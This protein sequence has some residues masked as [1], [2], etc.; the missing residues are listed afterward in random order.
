MAKLIKNGGTHISADF[1]KRTK[2]A[3]QHTQCE[4]DRIYTPQ[5]PTP[6]GIHN[7]MC[8]ASSLVPQQYIMACCTLPNHPPL[9][10]ERRCT[11]DV[12][13]L[14]KLGAH[15]D[16]RVPDQAGIQGHGLAQRV[17]GARARIEAHDE[18]VSVVVCRLQLLR[19]LGEEESAPVGHATHDT[20]SLE[21][22]SA[23]GFSDS[24]ACQM[25]GFRFA[26]SPWRRERG[27]GVE[28]RI[29]LLLRRGGQAGPIQ[30]RQHTV[31][32]TPTHTRYI[33][34]LSSRTA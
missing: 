17:L 10:S 5:S 31:H 27:S 12:G 2:R 26:R 28:G 13:N 15:L 32:L 30:A 34:L 21:Y 7:A 4:S 1:H 25:G 8:N 22:N 29:T 3:F 14:L 24:G 23:G 18:V 11:G 16:N 20:V 33:P 9:L 19:G 6:K